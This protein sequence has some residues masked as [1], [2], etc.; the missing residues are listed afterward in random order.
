ML[1]STE[2]EQRTPFEFPKDESF[3]WDDYQ[4]AFKRTQ[5]VYLNN[6]IQFCQF[7][8]PGDSILFMHWNSDMVHEALV[9]AFGLSAESLESLKQGCCV[10]TRNNVNLNF[11]TKDLEEALQKE[12]LTFSWYVAFTFSPREPLHQVQHLGGTYEI[13]KNVLTF[14]PL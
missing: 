1:H 6:L 13:Y 10:I 2:S 12:E 11:L 4:A 14:K 3:P 8:K 7:V 9:Q 5:Q